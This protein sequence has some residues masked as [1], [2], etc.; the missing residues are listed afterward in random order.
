MHQNCVDLNRHD[1]SEATRLRT[2]AML[3][4]TSML[5]VSSAGA[6]VRH[7]REGSRRSCCC[8]CRC[9][10]SGL[11]CCAWRCTRQRQQLA[12]PP[13]RRS[14]QQKLRTGGPSSCGAF[15]AELLVCHI[16]SSSR[17]Q[18]LHAKVFATWC[19]L[20]CPQIT[21]RCVHTCVTG[22]SSPAAVS[23]GRE[24]RD[25]HCAGRSGSWRGSAE[26][27]AGD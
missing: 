8:F 10:C 18:G 11:H 5:A 23:S 14:R 12:M 17:N 27:S 25:L 9:S 4:A 1:C 20:G 2:G 6:S 19:A 22:G 16:C 15:V 24:G 7:T 13:Q 3:L 21:A 26:R